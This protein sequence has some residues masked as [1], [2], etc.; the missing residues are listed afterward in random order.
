[1]HGD[2]KTS[3][4][5]HG[6][7]SRRSV[8]K[9]GAAIALA[10][11]LPQISFADTPQKG[12][13]LR[14]GLAHG[15]TSDSLDPAVVNT[16]GYL[17][18]L[19]QSMNNRLIGIA[20]DGTLEPELALSWEASDGAK[21]WAVKLRPGVEYHDGRTMKAEDVIASLRYHGKEDSTSSAKTL[22]NDVEDMKVDG[23]DTVVF[24]LAN[25][26][27]D[28]PHILADTNF[29]IRPSVDGE[30]DW[31]SN[32]STGPFILKEYEPG[33]RAFFVKNPNYFKEGLPH[34]DEL[35]L[36]TI[37]DQS[38]RTNAL[39][40]GSVDVIDRVEFKTSHLLGRN[41]GVKV[42]ETTGMLHYTLPMRS[43]TA[44]L[45]DNNVRL[46]LKYAINREDLLEKVLYGHGVV[47]NDHPVS[48]NNPFH[49][50]ELPQ[51]TY[52]PDKAKFH[53]KEAGLDKLSIPIHLADAAFAGAVDAGVL[54]REHAAAADIDLEVV[55]EP[56]DGYWSNVWM[57]KPMYASYWIG[58]T[59]TAAM[60]RLGYAATADWNEGFFQNERFN[61]LLT[62]V[63]S[64]LDPE[65]QREMYWEMQALLNE[66]GG[67][68]IPMFGNY[69][70]A[71]STK[72]GHGKMSG[73][74]DL[75][76]QKLA[77]RWWFNET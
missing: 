6:S 1:M 25:A 34:F 41:P 63:T 33:V 11:T 4:I 64:E 47:G 2:Q 36:L 16:H 70:F 76:G 9:Q 22:L 43:D 74:A 62:Q 48:I 65:V 23:A 32:A 53:L 69:V 14:V 28:F 10:T 29:M 67:S 19:N 68:V 72:L 5:S 50:S 7:H 57:K 46:A 12:G 39:I 71:V 27:T 8:L 30:M 77:E 31:Q 38:A 45:D 20:V 40:T 3:V 21:T 15:A 75:D 66:K 24:T 60:L 56:N 17:G 55:R 44:P 51:R 59:S 49:N 26:D 42:E 13:R 37:A 61:Q 58:R 54:Y 52:D 35:E 73:I 18:V